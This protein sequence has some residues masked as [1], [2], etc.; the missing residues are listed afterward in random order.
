MAAILL[1]PAAVEPVTLDE[2]K[3]HLGAKAYDGNDLTISAFIAGARIHV[4]CLSRRALITQTWR[5][6]IDAWPAGGRLYLYPAPIQE[7]VGA[8]VH[9][10]DGSIAVVDPMCFQVDKTRAPATADFIPWSLPLPGR[11]LAGIEID[12]RVGY[13]DAA[14]D[15]PE[16]L[17]RLILMLVEH[18][19]VSGRPG[20]A[21]VPPEIAARI[22][23]WRAPTELQVAR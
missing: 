17:R 2:A 5:C 3:A 4:E 21:H 9:G 6:Y 12:M 7:I 16:P 23:E 18:W 11:H 19:I 1:S 8:R 13:G 14:R 10:Q 15:V 20:S 22:T